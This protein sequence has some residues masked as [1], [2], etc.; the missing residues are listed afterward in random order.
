MRIGD[1]QRALVAAEARALA[2]RVDDPTARRG[3]EELAA[4][5]EAGEVPD[6]R[7]G[8]VLALEAVLSLSLETGR[9]RTAHGPAGARALA[10]LWRE[11]PGGR[12]ATERLAELNGALGALGGMPLGSIRF[13]AAGP[14][15]YTLLVSAG[16]L[17]AR[18][19]IDR[20]GVDLRGL[21][22]GGG[23]IGD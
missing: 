16:R 9:A 22:V 1:V 14:G 10:A 11:T 13:V 20:D 19:S 23:G 17:E 12:S 15:A 5:V 6:D 18:L 2:E 3:Y 4:L 7:P 8:A 21:T